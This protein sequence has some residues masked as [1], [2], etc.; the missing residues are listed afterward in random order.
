MPWLSARFELVKAAT[1]N[2]STWIERQVTTVIGSRRVTRQDYVVVAD[3][4]EWGSS[5]VC[6]V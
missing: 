2:E 5:W 6:V 3:L 1:R 4:D